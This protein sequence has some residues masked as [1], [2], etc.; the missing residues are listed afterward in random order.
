MFKMFDEM[1][2]KGY[3]FKEFIEFCNKF[4]TIVAIR[5]NKKMVQKAYTIY[6]DS[7]KV[8]EKIINY[9]VDLIDDVEKSKELID[10]QG[11]RFFRT[12]MQ[13]TFGDA[14]IQSKDLKRIQESE[15]TLR[16]NKKVKK[17]LDWNY[18]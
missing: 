15:S 5:K 8:Y 18:E 4:R 13:K 14:L 7:L 6:L 3:T 10:N 12:S 17:I 16:I 1:H 2:D 9:G 11:K